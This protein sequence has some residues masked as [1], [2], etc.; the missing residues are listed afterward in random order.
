VIDNS[1]GAQAWVTDDRFGPFKDTMLY[2]S[3]GTC[4]IFHVSYERVGDKV[5]GGVVKF[6]LGFD[7]G[8]MRM[9]MSPTDGQPW[10][11]GLKGWQTSANLDGML[12]RVRY[13]GK[14]V[15][16]PLEWHVKPKGISITFTNALDKASVADTENWLVEQWNYHWTHNYGS[17]EYSVKEPK[18]TGHDQVDVKAATLSADGRTVFLEL[19]EV[20]PVMQMRIKMDVKGADGAA[21]K[22]NIFTTINAVPAGE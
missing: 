3:Y 15:V 1:N 2:L 17:A 8:S 19:D 20:V 11:S 9:R 10:V 4:S 18:K 21:V 14:P 13:T 22:T 5:Q 6:P 12:A 7:S 16:M